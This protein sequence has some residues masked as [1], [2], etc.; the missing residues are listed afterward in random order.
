MSKN[1]IVTRDSFLSTEAVQRLYAELQDAK[2]LALQR[3]R[4]FS[5]IRD[6]YI[7]RTFLEAGP[8]C[9]E[10][11][12]LKVR[13]F[14]GKSLIIQ[15]GKGNKKREILLAPQTQKMLR[16]FLKL[17]RQVLDEP[18]LDNSYLFVSERKKPYSTRGL[19]KRVKYWFEKT[20]VAENLSV[21]SCRHTYISHLLAQGVDIQ[22]VRSNAG[23]S[24]LNTTSLYSHTLKKDL[25]GVE[26]YKSSDFNGKR[27]SSRKRKSED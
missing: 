22:T 27:N 5:H 10:L 17:K 7:L 20:G 6:Y 23:H 25:D 24:S 2:D 13:D 12:A 8:R 11:A 15:K 16:E 9:F 26:I 21:H 3:G 1:W 18:L 19:R 4:F 14:K